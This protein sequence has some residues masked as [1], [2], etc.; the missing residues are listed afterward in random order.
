MK[1][2]A[3]SLI[4]YLILTKDDQIRNLLNLSSSYTIAKLLCTF[5]NLDTDVVII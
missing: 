5:I 2:V 3:D 4:I 1:S